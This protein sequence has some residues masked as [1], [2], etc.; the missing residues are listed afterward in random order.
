LET[1]TT[2][3]YHRRKKKLKNVFFS[4]FKENAITK[5]SQACEPKVHKKYKQFFNYDVKPCGFIVQP[6]VLWLSYNLDEVVC[7]KMSCGNKKSQ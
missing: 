4:E 1:R 5:Y 2:I 3:L 6:R 7:Q